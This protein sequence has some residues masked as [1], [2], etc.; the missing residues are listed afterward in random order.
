MAMA[1]AVQDALF[2]RSL[3]SEVRL[4]PSG[5]TAMH[6]DNQACIA[7]MKNPMT[8]SRTK[9]IALRFHFVRDRLE[10]EEV[11]VVYCK[12]S[13]MLADLLTKPLPAPRFLELR[14]RFMSG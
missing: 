3:L 8:S 14:A 6:E 9:H 7:M 5:P 10:S 1:L 13:E 2:L 11:D 12:S 4:L